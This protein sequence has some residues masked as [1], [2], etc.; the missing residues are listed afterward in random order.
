MMVQIEEI[1][2][3]ALLMNLDGKHMEINMHNKFIS[4]ILSILFVIYIFFSVSCEYNRLLNPSNY[5]KGSQ[6]KPSVSISS[7]SDGH[8]DLHE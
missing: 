1:L 6:C 7:V 4:L 3:T 8:F 5:E 2:M